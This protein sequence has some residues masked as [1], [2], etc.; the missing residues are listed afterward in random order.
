METQ[1]IRMLDT[2]ETYGRVFAM[3]KAEKGGGEEKGEEDVVAVQMIDGGLFK[4]DLG[5]Y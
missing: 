3:A 5:K 2:V 4:L 1:Q